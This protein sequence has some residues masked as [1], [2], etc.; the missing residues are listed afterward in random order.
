MEC[1]QT[2]AETTAIYKGLTSI[3]PSGAMLQQATTLESVGQL[4]GSHLVR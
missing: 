3:G 2:V 1:Q 4:T